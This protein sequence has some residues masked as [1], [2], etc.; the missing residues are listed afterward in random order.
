MEIELKKQEEKAF[1]QRQEY[2]FDIKADTTPSYD[3]L[4]AEISKKLNV[5]AELVIVKKVEH[6]FGKSSV[7][8]SAYVYS[9]TDTLKKYEGIR[10]EKKAASTGETQPAK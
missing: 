2:T 8:V 10:E 6:Y 5:N 3:E 1:F 7:L 4:K 9:S